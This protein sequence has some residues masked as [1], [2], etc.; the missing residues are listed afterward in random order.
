VLVRIKGG[1]PD[2]RARN[3]RSGFLVERV[4]LADLLSRARPTTTAGLRAR[5]RTRRVARGPRDPTREG[6]RA[7][8]DGRPRDERG[9]A[10]PRSRWPGSLPRAR[11]GR[12][13]QHHVDRSPRRY[14]GARSHALGQRAVC[15][16]GR[17]PSRRRGRPRN[18]RREAGSDERA[19][20]PWAARLDRGPQR[21][22]G[23]AWSPEGRIAQVEYKTHPEAG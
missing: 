22:Y 11:L 17:S 3:A 12:D 7:R 2:D 19:Q 21:I 1:F 14:R 23:R 10:D 9:A 20:L 13:R 8:H 18:A 16:D 4:R 15:D 5:R 6:A